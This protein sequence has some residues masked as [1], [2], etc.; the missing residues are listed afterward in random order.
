MG[1]FHTED[2]EIYWEYRR[3]SESQIVAPALR[4][5]VLIFFLL[6]TFVFIPADWLV[7]PDQ[8]YFF[9]IARLAL[10]VFLCFIY[11]WAIDKFP[12]ASASAVCAAGAGLFLAM[13]YQTGGADSGYYVGLIL[14]IIG[15]GVLVP[16][17]GKQACSIGGM[18]FISY[19]LLPFYAKDPV[20][21]VAFFQKLFFLGAACIEAVWAC[22]YMD[23]MRFLDFKQKR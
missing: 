21:W 17:S 10:N 8:F 9:L 15:L 5:A 22:A 20:K 3:I 7:F 14:L 23:R 11:F 12:V 19:M 1:L 18:F 6:Q 16:L 13:V 2:T 4:G